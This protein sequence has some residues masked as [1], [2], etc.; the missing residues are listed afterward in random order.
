MSYS[1]ALGSSLIK[2]NPATIPVGAIGYRYSIQCAIP[3]TASGQSGYTTPITLP[4]GVWLVL[5]NVQNQ[6]SAGTVTSSSVWTEINEVGVQNFYNFGG[7][8]VDGIQVCAVV[9]SSGADS[10][11]LK[12]TGNTSAL[13][14]WFSSTSTPAQNLL[15]VVRIA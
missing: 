6:A 14:T 9:T 7:N 8:T 4:Q 2:E 10:L 3:E 11:R 5:G 12:I 15:Y 13:D 1:S